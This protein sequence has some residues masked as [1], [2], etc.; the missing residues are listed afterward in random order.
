MTLSDTTNLSVH[1]HKPTMDERKRSIQ[2]DSD[3]IY[4]SKRHQTTQNAPQM[5]M[6]SEKEKDV[7]SFQKD[8]I[9]RQMKEYKREKTLYESQ[10]Q[11]LSKR[12]Q[13]H[14]DHLRIVDSWFTQ[15]LDEIRIL[16]G[17]LVSDQEPEAGELFR[18][19]LLFDEHS[20]FESHLKNRSAKIKAAIKDVFGRLPAAEP[21]VRSLQERLAALLATEKAHVIESQRIIGERDQLSERLEQAS[22]RY[23]LAEKKLD[24]AK[25]AQVQ[26]LERQATMGGTSESSSTS[27]KKSAKSDAVETNGEVDSAVHAAAETARREA[28]AAS[29]KRKLQTEQLEAE[30][31]Q[32]TEELTSAKVRLTS[33]SDEDYA[34]TDLYKLLKSQHEDVIKRVN[35]LEATNLQLREEAQRLQAERTSYRNNMEEESQTNATDLESQLAR[36]ESDLARIRN[37]RDELSAELSVRKGSQ[38]QSQVASDSIK[39]LAAARETRIA[40]LESEVERLK[41][42]IGESTAATTDEALEGMSIEE[43]RS[44][45]KTLENQHLLLNNELP[46]MEA[47]WKKTKSLAERKVAEIVEWEEQRTRI[48]AEKAKADQKYFAAMKAKEAR[49]NE[50]RTL[51][52]Q[53]AKSSEI[54]TQ[55]KDAENNSRSLIINLEKQ[56]SESKESLTSLSQ[57]NRTMQQKLS[58]GNITLEKLRTQITDMKKLVVSKDAASSAAASAKRQA[59]VE[60][61]EVKV[62]LEDTKRSLESMKRKGSG[63]ESESDDWRKIAICPVCNSNLR[64]TVLKLCSHTFC[65]GCVQNLIANRSR[66]C[67]SCGK[68][69]G[70]ADHMPIVLA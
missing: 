37:A 10:V 9:L 50:L 58:E 36:A 53:N 35:D 65:Q 4:P 57:Q 64:N 31:K 44:K 2:P 48:N 12:S 39:E 66:K 32:L 27:E 40:A 70:H 63:R 26:K 18:S 67:P 20:Q 21:E 17:D 60:L 34:K 23:L 30:N 13:Y 11:D 45:L 14:D 5:R 16:V 7:E 25:S 61:E 42:Q 55:L 68:A 24:R 19:S 51:K 59:E 41:L 29:E 22:Y 52:A 6:D 1:S 62:R 38:E 43:L 56:I 33:L 49:E 46:S 47:A 54:V 8:A 3:D 69:F 15:L 28:L